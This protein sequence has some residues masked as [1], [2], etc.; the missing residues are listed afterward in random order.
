VGP[1][2]GLQA[3]LGQAE[4]AHLAGADRVSDRAGHV[5]DGHGRVHPVLDQHVDA[6]GAQA[7]QLGIHHLSDMLGP[8]V[9]SA[10]ALTAGRVDVE[11]ELRL[12]H[13]PVAPPLQGLADDVFRQKGP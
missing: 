8:A 1:A 9:Q 7:P 11:A 13:H 3:R 6:V 2:H 4:L 5:L 10:A 12:Q